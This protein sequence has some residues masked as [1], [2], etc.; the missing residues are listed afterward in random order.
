M[1]LSEHEIPIAGFVPCECLFADIPLKIQPGTAWDSY[2]AETEGYLRKFVAGLVNLCAIKN[3]T[4][5]ND[6]INSPTIGVSWTVRPKEAKIRPTSLEQI[7]IDT[8]LP[9]FGNL[10]ELTTTNTKDKIHQQKIR[11]KFNLL[12]VSSI[13]KT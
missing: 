7:D 12:A 10:G 6:N 9:I 3:D 5:E 8:I 11:E 2:L 1:T 4:I 13:T